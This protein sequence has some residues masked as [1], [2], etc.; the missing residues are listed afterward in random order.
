[1]CHA[2]GVVVDCACLCVLP[3]AV[4][5]WCLLSVFWVLLRVGVVRCCSLLLV[6]VVCCCGLLCADICVR[7]LLLCDVFFVVYRACM[8]VLVAAIL[9]FV[10]S[11]AFLS[12][13]VGCSWSLLMCVVWC[14]LLFVVVR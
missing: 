11:V 8:L 10:V 14:V 12:I 5:G 13:D 7:L 6:V 2:L 1:M 9:W 3:D 4:V